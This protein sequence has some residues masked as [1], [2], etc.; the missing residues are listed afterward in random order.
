MSPRLALV[1]YI[2]FAAAWLG[3]CAWT[4]R[5]L[6]FRAGGAER[7]G[8][9]MWGVPVWLAWSVTM[10]LV[11]T[12]G[13]LLSPSGLWELGTSLVVGFPLFLWAG[14][15]FGAVMGRLFP[16]PPERRPGGEDRS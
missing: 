16:Q 14:Y 4:A 5:R 9:L 10:A 2:C 7:K 11:D 13:G 12:E 6:L 15:F 8:V 1:L 3:F